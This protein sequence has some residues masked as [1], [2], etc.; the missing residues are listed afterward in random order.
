[1]VPEIYIQIKDHAWFH[2]DIKEDKVDEILSSKFNGVFIVTH[3]SKG[4]SL[5]V[6]TVRG[7]LNLRVLRSLTNEFYLLEGN[8]FK[9]INQL[10]KNYHT[11]S[12]YETEAVYLVPI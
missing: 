1:M 6:K 3:T 12:L 9:S 7:V 5:A 2:D 10:V 11:T 8:R 4:F